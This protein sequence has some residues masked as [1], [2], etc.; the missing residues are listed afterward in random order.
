MYMMRSGGSSRSGLVDLLRCVGSGH[1]TLVEIGSYAGESAEVFLST[2]L[3]DRI[4]CVDP[5][6]SGYDATDEASSSDMAEVE[7]AFDKR[8]SGDSRVVKIKG[9]ID[10]FVA[11]YG[12]VLGHVDGVYIDGCHLPECVA[13]DISVSMDKIRPSRFIAGHD[14]NN[15]DWPVR[16]VVVSMLGD[17]HDVFSDDSWVVYIG[18]GSNHSRMRDEHPTRSAVVW[19]SDGGDFSYAR[20]SVA[21]MRIRLDDS[22]DFFVIADKSTDL[23]GLDEIYGVTRIDPAPYL[24]TLGFDYTEYAKLGRSWRFV[25]LYRLIIPL[26]GRFTEY[27]SVLYLDG[28]TFALPDSE[29]NPH[30]LLSYVVAG[31]EVAGVPDCY[32]HLSRRNKGLMNSPAITGEFRDELLRRVWEPSGTESRSYVN[33][34]VMLW[35]A[36]SID[37]EWYIRRCR[38]FWRGIR[39]FSYN[40]QDFVNV[41]MRVDASVKA[42]F[43]AMFTGGG[44]YIVDDACIR[45]CTGPAK[46]QLRRAGARIPEISVS[47]RVAQARLA[48]R[49]DPFPVAGGR[50]CIVWCCDSY[51]DY[52]GLVRR[53]ILSAEQQCGSALDGVDRF[54]LV[55]SEGRPAEYNRIAKALPAGVS[56]VDVSELVAAIG[57]HTIDDWRSGRLW[58]SPGKLIRA[59][60][61]FVP[62]LSDYPVALYMDADTT[63]VDGRFADVFGTD[64]SGYDCAMAGEFDMH[65]GLVRP[66]YRVRFCKAFVRTTDYAGEFADAILC[67]LNSGLYFNAGVF[68]ANMQE[69]R[70]TFGSVGRLSLIIGDAVKRG[71]PAVWHDIYNYVCNVCRL[72]SAYNS[73]YRTHEWGSP[74]YCVHSQGDSKSYARSPSGIPRHLTL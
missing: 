11:G 27:K 51:P 39:R 10:D 73:F 20:Y 55:D 72:P 53:S 13:H 46:E 66:F 50:R 61:P 21:S 30:E 23:H 4:Y 28:D 44:P 38:H 58:W 43:N 54:V 2:G 47:A 36:R 70:R 7:S 40:D 57:A 60:I 71:A 25:V 26:V 52:P 24:K 18:D 22:C 19:A 16:D 3:V 33:A 56:A 63:V 59:V 14:Y 37:R 9:T 45:H 8:F 68:L 12:E 6:R 64:L 48:P 65:Y 32:M 17:A 29:N 34:G 69:M 31:A 1:L 49:R 67:R 35:Y 15:R 5:W 42:E 62:E 74:V 41:M